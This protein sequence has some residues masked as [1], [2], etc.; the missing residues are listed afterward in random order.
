[1]DGDRL[2]IAQFGTAQ[3]SG[4]AVPSSLGQVY[5]DHHA[6]TPVD[7][8]VVEIVMQAMVQVFGNPHSS[9]HTYGQEAAALLD[10]SRA[11]VGELVGADASQ[12]RFTSGAT[13]ALRIALAMAATEAAGKVLRVALSRA[14]HA[15]VIE[16]IMRME[17]FGTA[18]ITWLST[19]GMGRVDLG[20]IETLLETGID[21]LC[22][23][24]ANNEIGTIHPVEAAAALVADAG[25]AI[26]VDA[27]QAAGRLEIR[28]DEW[29]LDY[30]V[31][32]AHK[33]YGPKGIGALIGPKA[34]GDLAQV[35]VGHEGTPNVPGIAGLGEAARLR[36]LERIEDEVRITLLRDH[37]EAALESKIPGLIVNG[38][39]RLRLSHNL[40]VAIPGAFNEA[41]VAR[42]R[43]KV[44]LS[45]GSACMSG[46]QGP[47]HVLRAINLPADLLDCVLRI[48]PGKFNTMAEIDCAA[49]DI[50]EAAA[51]VRTAMG[52]SL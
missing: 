51:S 35:A 34:L 4:C 29:N 9:D 52:T 49:N 36:Q 19:D 20:E 46:A 39:R 26:L 43:G 5:L 15:A 12:V 21:L 28:A 44:A 30:L 2:N 31:L 24:A 22:L 40:H 27:T 42:L 3:L 16:P 13:E 38:D 17:Q 47:S 14:E 50:A 1:M 25:A 11:S 10:R 48:S 41:V 23:M 8:R 32:S 45:T 6:T 33:L 18:Q 37:L 7:P